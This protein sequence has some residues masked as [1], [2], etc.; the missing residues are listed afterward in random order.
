MNVRTHHAIEESTR[1]GRMSMDYF[2]A[3]LDIL[4]NLDTEKKMAILA[5]SLPSPYNTAQRRS[6]SRMKELPCTI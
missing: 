4:K 1:E 2:S 5:F 6:K 3:I